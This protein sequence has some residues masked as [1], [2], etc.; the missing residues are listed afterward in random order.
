ME[1][2]CM[3]S[4]DRF[5]APLFTQSFKLFCNLVSSAVKWVK[6]LI[7]STLHLVNY[8]CWLLLPESLHVKDLIL[9]I[10]ACKSSTIYL[11]YMIIVALVKGLAQIWCSLNAQ[12]I[13]ITLFFTPYYTRV[14]NRSF[15]IMIWKALW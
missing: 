12:L 13:V 9:Q 6:L 3:T 2:I 11:I 8:K 1:V 15:W 10:W 4:G 5:L 7:T 14:T